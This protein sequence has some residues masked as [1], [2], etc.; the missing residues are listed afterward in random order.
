MGELSYKLVKSDREL[1][2]AF[3]VRKKVFV[4]E[5]GIAECLEFD[6]NDGQALHMVVMDGERVIG[7]ARV[8][9]LAANQAKLERMAILKSFR[10]KGIGR[11]WTAEDRQRPPRPFT[12]EALASGIREPGR[13]RHALSLRAVVHTAKCR[14]R[15]TEVLDASGPDHAHR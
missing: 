4:D 12:V 5:Q 15:G 8:L 9:F 7:T 11:K 10:R 14:L 13:P 6:G 3:E 2:E 1:K